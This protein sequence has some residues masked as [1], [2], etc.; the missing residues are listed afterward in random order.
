M[1]F[2]LATI[3][4][5]AA[6]TVSF[7]TGSGKEISSN[8][9]ATKSGIT[10]T[11][12]DGTSNPNN[13][14]GTT[15]VRLQAGGTIV[16][17][18]STGITITQVVL[19][20]S[21]GYEKTWS[22]STGNAP[23]TDTNAHTVTWSG[24]TTSSIT[25]T[26]TA[27]AQSRISSIA[28]TYESSSSK[29]ATTLSFGADYDEQT[30]TKY[31]DA[32]SF[33]TQATLTG[34]PADATISYSSSNTS[35]A[36]IDANGNV[37]LAGAGTTTI[38]A[39]YAGND[40]YEGSTAYYTLK[41]NKLSS[42]VTLDQ[43]T[44][45]MNVG[46]AD[47][48]L[49]ATVSVT[50]GV[51]TF[52]SANTNV[53]TVD[54]S[55]GLVHAVGVG[56]T[57]ITASYEGNETY[58]ASTATCQVTVSDPS[59]TGEVYTLVTNA[60]D[61]S[62]GDVIILTNTAHLGAMG[63][64]GTKTNRPIVTDG[65]VFSADNS[66]AT[67]STEDIK[68]ITL[69]TGTK[70]GTY[71]LLTDEGYLYAASSSAN[72]LKSQE[73]IDD[74]ASAT[75]TFSSGAAS[76]KFSGTNTRNWLKYNATSEI[77][78]CYS[79]GQQ[80][81][82]IYKKDVSAVAKPVISP[83]GG[84]FEGTQDIAI[85]AEE[86]CTIYYT[87][88]GTDPT[89]SSTQYTGVFAIDASC[90]VKAIAVNANGEVS[91]VASAT[92]KNV[93]LVH[94]KNIAEF[95][96]LDDDTQVVFDNSVVVL[97]DYAQKL[98]STGHDYIWIKDN[99]GYTQIYTSSILNSIK[100]TD[101]SNNAKYENGDVIPAGFIATKNYY[102]DGKYR[103]AKASTDTELAS[104]DEATLKAVADPELITFAQFN[105]L[106]PEDD[107]N[108]AAWNNHYILLK[109]VYFTNTNGKF[110]ALYDADGTTTTNVMYNKY[111]NNGSL[112]KD[113]SSAVVEV[114]DDAT[115]S[116][117]YNIYGI[118]QIYNIKV[119]EEYKMAWEIL[120]IRFEEH[121]V[122]S[123]TLKELV[124]KGNNGETNTE[125]DY[126]IT[127]DLQGVA[128]YTDNANNKT[129][130]LVKDNND[131]VGK[132]TKADGLESYLIKAE[133]NFA[134][135]TAT[136]VVK[137]EKAQEEY[138]QSNWL[139]IEVPA[140]VTEAD[141]VDK[142][143]KGG[144][145]T[146]RYTNTVNPRLVLANAAALTTTGNSEAYY[147]NPMTPANFMSNSVAGNDQKN[148]FFMTPKPNEYVQVVYAVY[149]DGFFYL[150]DANGGNA[151]EF[152]AKVAISTYD[153]NV[154]TTPNL[155]NG[156]AYQFRA[157]MKNATASANNAARKAGQFE[158]Q[159]SDTE[160]TAYVIYPIN[161][162]HN[163]EIVTGVD[164]VDAVKTVKSVRFYNVAGVAFGEA[165]P[166]INIVVTEYTDGSHSTAKVI[167]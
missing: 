158:P 122:A 37:T 150:P 18:P 73:S 31:V 54:A 51:V 118:C 90:T 138:D 59:I 153:Y 8:A 25:L 100:G 106:T 157:I 139:E 126:T 10:I 113:G 110:Y 69:E 132:V 107:A 14:G 34:G 93:E 66:T 163:N 148:Y 44:L 70:E 111:S 141:Y 58:Y 124:A 61:L 137:N 79:S 67:V 21:S 53:A 3:A 146:G 56:S 1:F 133:S 82:L 116:K 117:T 140:T 55:T 27:S 102:A 134:G 49:A 159:A 42:T 83:N 16:V 65:I 17:T 47:V 142:I 101:A 78:S 60:D 127:N 5:Q 19:N 160:G 97:Y 125:T 131:A 121:K 12:T 28:V 114:P 50:G 161:L 33:Q 98:A 48:T 11:C 62:E 128:L 9:G 52:S 105:E 26:N 123:L 154:T 151:N 81:V 63:K 120:P 92:F 64:Q 32:E 39:A 96:A 15:Y 71:A 135:T 38:S 94:V 115:A 75:I 162:Q 108:L 68:T 145:I 43:T 156:Y 167:R 144:T 24:S 103:Q 149:K 85:T 72:Q 104:F 30:I 109:N 86:G 166:G 130:L 20:C 45:S 29:T 119:D 4:V 22:A 13:W 95:N 152:A 57:T 23:V 77:F 164:G 46:E 74:N 41:V 40:T 6:T 36:T 80:L 147:R 88:D 143:I 35:V 155:Q 136:N 99:S 165:Q 129:I 84:E 2:L 87:T 91:S 112:S 89:T 7:T 76:I